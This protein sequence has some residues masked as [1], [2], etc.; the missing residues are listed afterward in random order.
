MELIRW[1]HT[2]AVLAG[3]KSRRMG[4]P[5]E[6]IPLGDGRPMIGHVL[7]ALQKVCLRT[8]IVGEC[9]GFDCPAHTIH[10]QDL[11]RGGGPLAGVETLLRSG[12]D[13]GYLVVA[14][15]QPLLS[16]ALLQ[17]VVGADPARPC[18]LRPDDGSWLGPFPGYFPAACLERVDLA[19]RRGETSL[20]RVFADREIA[21]VPIS[22]AEQPQVKNFNSPADLAELFPSTQ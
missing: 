12:L 1:P 15:D 5:K 18:Y 19:I 13:T 7:A 4:K 8:V 14:C 2:G 22:P 11:R 9:L 6:G 3:G 16:P 21:W 20:R 10:L 17:R